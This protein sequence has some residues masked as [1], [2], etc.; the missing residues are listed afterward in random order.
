MVSAWIQRLVSTSWG[1][2]LRLFAALASELQSKFYV[3]ERT[4]LLHCLAPKHHVPHVVPEPKPALL[5]LGRR[6][7]LGPRHKCSG[8]IFEERFAGEHGE[9]LLG[10]VLPVGGEVNVA[11]RHET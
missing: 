2:P 6:P 4:R 10:V 9:H 8:R 1:L 5:E 11:A 3:N 7:G